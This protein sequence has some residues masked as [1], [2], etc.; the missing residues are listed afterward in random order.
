MAEAAVVTPSAYGDGTATASGTTDRPTK[1][2]HKASVLVRP[3][4]LYKRGTTGAHTTATAGDAITGLIAPKT[5]GRFSSSNRKEADNALT[6]AYAT[7]DTT[8]PTSN[9]GRS[10]FMWT[11]R[12]AGPNPRTR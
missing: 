1:K 3:S 2:A 11:R 9:G 4:F 8:A 6:K 5:T 12:P 10:M 7:T